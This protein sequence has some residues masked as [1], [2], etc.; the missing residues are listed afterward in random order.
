MKFLCQLTHS[1]VIAGT[2]THT[3]THTQTHTD[4][5]KTL[6]L[7]HTRGVKIEDAIIRG[8]AIFERNTEIFYFAP[9]YTVS[10]Q[11]LQRPKISALNLSQLLL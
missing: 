4:T 8:G 7:P 5:T 9:K 1:K 6:P 11:S 10:R 3:H 2:D